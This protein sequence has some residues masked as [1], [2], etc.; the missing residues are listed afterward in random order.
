MSDL[1]LLKGEWT[2]TV[3][4]P[5]GARDSS[6]VFEEVDGE[7]KGVQS[8]DGSEDHIDQIDFDASNGEIAWTNQIQKPMKLKLQ[9]KGVVE[10]SSMTG[11]VSTGFMGAFPF[12]AVKA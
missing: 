11:K 1:D 2:V 7:L 6:L 3:K 4:A 8:S 9:F 12:S 10:G 5:T